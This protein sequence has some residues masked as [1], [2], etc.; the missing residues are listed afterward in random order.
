VSP[1]LHL[2]GKQIVEVLSMAACKVSQ[3]CRRFGQVDHPFD[4]VFCS[5]PRR[6]VPLDRC[7]ATTRVGA[8]L[9]ARFL[10]KGGYHGSRQG[11]AHAPAASYPPLQKARKD[12]APSVHNASTNTEEA[13]HLPCASVSDVRNLCRWRCPAMLSDRQVAPEFS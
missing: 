4:S 12:G 3:N 8:P 1:K 10:A 5:R 13:G 6:R 2:T 9:F 7:A 11:T